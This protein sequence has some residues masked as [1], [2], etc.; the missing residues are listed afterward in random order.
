M[1][2]LSLLLSLFTLAGLEASND[3]PAVRKLISEADDIVVASV[4]KS[5]QSP[6]VATNIHNSEL[7]VIRSL[8][9]RLK[10]GDKVWLHYQ[11][12]FTDFKTR[13]ALSPIEVGN[14]YIFFINTDYHINE[15][16]DRVPEYS[17]VDGLIPCFHYSE[18]LASTLASFISKDE[19]K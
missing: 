17:P 15:E 19:S 10:P 6:K 8:K 2:P 18:I 12:F 13:K 3:F 14:V 1:K 5:T 16:G 4:A 11:D 7:A 9:G